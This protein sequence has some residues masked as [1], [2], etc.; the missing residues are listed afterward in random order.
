MAST[1]T[2]EENKQIARRFAEEVV[3][4]SNYNRIDEL[5]AEGMIDH[6]PLGETRGRDELR[7]TMKQ[8]GSAFPDFSVTPY[9]VIMEGDTV[10]ARMTQ[11]GTHEGKFM[12][13]EPTGRTIDVE[14][15]VFMHLDNQQI[16]ERWV[17][18]DMLDMMQQL[19]VAEPFG[20]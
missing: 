19:G 16:T 4:E 17:H 1:T 20:K 15:M 11:Q 5:V 8:L 13:V 2:H 7:E 3:N 9:E 18:I 14:A 12:G 10:A 6:T